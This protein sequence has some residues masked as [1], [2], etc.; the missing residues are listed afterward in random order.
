MADFSL[1]SR[2]TLEIVTPDRSLVRETVDEVQVP[3]AEGYMGILHGHTPYLATLQ[4]G[5]LSYRIG[6]QTTNLHVAFGFVEVL[7]NRVTVL[8]QVAERAEDIDVERAEAARRRAED[9]ISKPVP[10]MDFERARIAMMKS[11][12]RLQVAGRVKSRV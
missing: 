3:A 6:Q 10:E 7:P 9:R 4:V 12:I 5:Q 2:L 11:L 1:P 8:A